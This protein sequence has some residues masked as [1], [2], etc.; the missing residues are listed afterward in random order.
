[1]ENVIYAISQLSIE[2]RSQLSFQIMGKY[3]ERYEQWLKGETK[4]MG[5]ENCV[6]FMGFVSGEEKYYRLSK[7]SALMVPSV[8]ENF[9][10]IVPEALVCGTPVYA[11]LGTPWEEL[12]EYN[13]GWWKDNEPET[14]AGVISEI[15]SATDG[16]LLEKGQN[17]NRLIE[18]KYEQHK[19]AEMMKHLYEWI[20]N[21]GVKPDFVYV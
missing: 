11:S 19:V 8:Q 12:N 4:R 1:M 3:D 5:L 17:G 9:G 15:L 13:A 2:E 21:G 6:E 20:V 10:M 16:Q 18:R 14:I 7:L